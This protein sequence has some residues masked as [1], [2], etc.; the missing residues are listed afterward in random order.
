V[1]S[2]ERP[3]RPI[4]SGQ[5]GI[6]SAFLI[7]LGLL[8][9]GL[10]LIG[11]LVVLGLARPAALLS[12]SVLGTTIIVYDAWHKTNP[13]G[14]AL[15]GICRGLVY[16]TATLATGGSL[17][18][19]VWLAAFGVA[20][21]V[22]GLTHVAKRERRVGAD[23]AAGRVGR[24]PVGALIAG[25]CLVDAALVAGSGEPLLALFCASGC[26]LTLALQARVSGT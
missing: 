6:V 7:G 1:D 25:I 19:A 15:M 9:I 24:S 11:S 20:C 8:V 17:S 26:L 16:V 4:P 2:V 23:G 3:E 18:G 21:Y 14:P 5:V 13:V 12:A 10:L 22:L